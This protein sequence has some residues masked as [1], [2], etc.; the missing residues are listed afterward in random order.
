MATPLFSTE[1]LIAINAARKAAK[2]ILDVYQTDFVAEIRDGE[3]VTEADNR[4]NDVI[5]KELDRTGYPILSEESFDDLERLNQS[6][7]WIVDPLDGTSDF[8]KKTGEFSV[9]IGLVDNKVPV[10][11][12]VY[13]PTED[14]LY[15]AEKG[16]GAYQQVSEEWSRLDVSKITDIALASVLMSRS[17]L[18]ESEEVFLNDLGVSKFVQHGSCGLKVAKIATGKADLYFSMTTKIKQ[19]DTCAAACIIAEAGGK[20]TDMLGNDLIYNIAELNHK[21]GILVSNG[22]FSKKIVVAYKQLS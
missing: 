19:W 16:V 22:N 17:H 18:A 2:E 12:V 15:V 6:K 3:P 20:I 11:G 21:N 9:M 7:V 1:T 14:T 4:S 8:V 5:I 13:Q 10:V